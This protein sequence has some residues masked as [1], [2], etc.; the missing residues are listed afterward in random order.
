MPTPG[1]LE[2]GEATPM[3][4][5]AARELS[6]H[7]RFHYR[8][9]R[10]TPLTLPHET[11][12]RFMPWTV[13]AQISGGTFDVILPGDRREAG[14]AGDCLLAPDLRHRLVLTSGRRVR[15]RWAH[16]DFTLFESLNLLTLFELPVIVRGPAARRLG[17]L[18]ERM[19]A[20]AGR[21]PQD[22]LLQAV[23]LEHLGFEMLE[24]LLRL[25]RPR[26]DFVPFF[27]R[28]QRFAAVLGLIARE[29]SRAL[30]VKELA[31]AAGLSPSR[32]QAAFREAFGVSPMAYVRNHR[33]EQGRLLLSSTDLIARQVAGRVGYRDAFH[34]SRHFKRRFGVSPTPFRRSIHP[35]Q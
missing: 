2:R 3:A 32:F 30:T 7:L 26:E 13:I 34:F 33:L 35:F 25:G 9:G 17:E 31:T 18:C 16:L 8:D 20:T 23:A 1:D 27:S 21:S 28:T 5:L 10:V 15:S 14:R 22:D 29:H 19:A 24:L 12:W 11:P 6:E 4:T